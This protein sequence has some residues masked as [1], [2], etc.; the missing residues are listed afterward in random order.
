MEVLTAALQRFSSIL[1]AAR[2]RTLHA[3]NL[4]SVSQC[5]CVVFACLALP[6]SEFYCATKSANNWRAGASQLI[7]ARTTDTIF[8][9]NNYY[10]CR[11][12]SPTM[13]HSPIPMG[14]R[15]RANLVVDP[16]RTGT[17]FQ[18]T[19]DLYRA[20]FSALT[21]TIR[22]TAPTNLLMRT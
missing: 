18:Y 17:I 8:L 5:A 20:L 19:H 2:A 3:S 4:R 13:R 12:L 9:Y 10:I 14:E 6:E 11:S 22:A 21:H 1:C 16:Y 7:V 15:E